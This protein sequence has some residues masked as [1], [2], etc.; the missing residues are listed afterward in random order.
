MTEQTIKLYNK[1]TPKGEYFEELI[2]DGDTLYRSRY[3]Y[4]QTNNISETA[5]GLCAN[6]NFRLD[7]IKGSR[8]SLSNQCSGEQVD[9]WTKTNEVEIYSK[10][11]V[12]IIHQ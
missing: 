9:L 10:H 1:Q 8:V 6:G 4:Y 5:R 7:K 2:Y 11:K 3:R 12:S